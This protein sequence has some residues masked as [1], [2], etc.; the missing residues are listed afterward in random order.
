[1]V[2]RLI[3][4]FALQ[5]RMAYWPVLCL[6]STLLRRTRLSTVVARR[7]RRTRLVWR[8]MR[9]PRLVLITWRRRI[10]VIRVKRLAMMSKSC[11]PLKMLGV[12]VIQLNNVPDGGEADTI[13]D[14]R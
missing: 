11:V 2:Q 9:T 5:W 7:L 1:M 10:P 3:V 8:G 13:K 12:L 4:T 6:L 14:D